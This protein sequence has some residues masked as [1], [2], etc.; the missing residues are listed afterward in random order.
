MLIKTLITA[1]FAFC[2]GPLAAQAVFVP[3]GLDPSFANAGKFN[4]TFAG[5][6]FRLLA[7]LQRPDGTSVGV[8]YYDNNL[9]CP[10]GRHCLAL[11]PFNAAGALTGALTVPQTGQA[12]FSKRTGGIVLDPVLIKAAAI[13]SQGRI[14]IVGT[15]QFGSLFDFKVVRLLPTGQPDTTFDGDGVQ[16]I[17]FNGNEDLAFGVSIE[18][19]TDK[20]VVVGQVRL[21]ATDTDFGV[22]RLLANGALDPFFN[23][24]GKRTVPFDLSASNTD[25]AIA[26]TATGNLIYIA[27]TA[28]DNGVSRIALT[29]L[30]NSG[31]YNAGFC[32][33]SCSFQG[34]YSAINS[35]RRVIFYGTQGATSDFV[36]AASVNL[37]SSPAEWVYAGTRNSGAPNFVS[38]A[39]IQK[40]AANGDYANEALTDGGYAST[41]QYR[42]GGV[43]WVNP[44]VA[45]SGIVLT[46]TSGLDGIAFFAQG[47]S[48]ALVATPNWGAA[49]PSN[50]V[51][52]YAATG[53]LGDS[54]GMN[55]PAQSSIDS[56]GRVLLGGSYLAGN[57]NAP[58]YSIS[59]ARFRG[60][61]TVPT[62]DSIFKNGFEN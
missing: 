19:T 20:I 53:G 35:G 59:I 15:E 49:G 38:E 31:G 2:A 33:G 7:H 50:S 43:H 57:T 62:A 39:F 60:G 40:L 46:G 55:L 18:P 24:T 48:S 30:L 28:T 25:R 3:Y 58:P 14:V 8:A 10:A 12:T 22:V 61:L 45:N 42:M 51:A 17:D 27:G 1:A 34:S 47:M 36:E 16:T 52:L 29:R 37:A 56:A 41:T 54:N 44:N 9:G 13:D 6:D 26:V 23:S 5:A 4:G 32:S 11:Y 21:S